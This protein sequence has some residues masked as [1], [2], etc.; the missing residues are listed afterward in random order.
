MCCVLME[1]NNTIPKLVPMKECCWQE[2]MSY[3][4]HTERC[5]GIIHM[6]PKTF[7]HLCQ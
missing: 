3:L 7:I 6:S 1:T 5:H 4:I 2:L